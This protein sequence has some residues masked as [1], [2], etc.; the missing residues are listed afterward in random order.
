MTSGELQ[1]CHTQET[2]GRTDT[3]QPP[4]LLVLSVGT[5][6]WRRLHKTVCKCTADR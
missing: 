4:T 6:T 3:L 2:N 5:R 1:R